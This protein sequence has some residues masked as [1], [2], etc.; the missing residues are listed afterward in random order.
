MKKIILFLALLA[1]NGC[2]TVNTYEVF[3]V[4]DDG[5]ALARECEPFGSLCLGKIVLLTRRES[6]FYDGLKVKIQNPT[7]EGTF[8]YESRDH[9]TR[10]VPVLH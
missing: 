1:L 3:Q 5:N 4:L 2:A 8:R 9:L 7:I 10:T 6:S